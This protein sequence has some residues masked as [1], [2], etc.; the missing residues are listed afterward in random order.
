MLYKL[1]QF[2]AFFLYK[3]ANLITIGNLSPLLCISI[4][5]VN[6]DRILAI[7]HHDGG[8][9]TLPGG[10]IK[11]GELISQAALRE[12]REETGYNIQL[13]KYIG[14]YERMTGDWF[15]I[16]TVVLAFEAEIIGGREKDS[17]E[18]TVGWVTPKQIELESDIIQNYLSNRYE[19]KR[20][21]TRK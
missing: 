5:V 3:F 21:H 4:I 18:G 7:N 14:L 15:H 19:R 16:P 12:V 13:K 6:R 20:N 8:G 11:Q 10:V 1:G 17:L 2:L 9:F